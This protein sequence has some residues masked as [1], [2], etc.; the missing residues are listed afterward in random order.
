MEKVL[1]GLRRD[2]GD[3]SE[4][5]VA[6]PVDPAFP[7]FIDWIVLNLDGALREDVS[8][9]SVLRQQPNLMAFR[10]MPERSTHLVSFAFALRLSSLKHL[11]CARVRDLYL[12]AQQSTRRRR[13]TRP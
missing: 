8:S 12:P 7:G 1:R 2:N 10:K 4:V 9:P 5:W 6:T 13:Y 3:D 11:S